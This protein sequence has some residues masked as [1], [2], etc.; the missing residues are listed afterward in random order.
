MHPKS[1]RVNPAR[2][3]PELCEGKV[4]TE[5]FGLVEADD[6]EV[7]GNYSANNQETKQR[8]LFPLLRCSCFYPVVISPPGTTRRA[9]AKKNISSR[10]QIGMQF[11]GGCP[12]Q[13]SVA[14]KFHISVSLDGD[15]EDIPAV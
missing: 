9:A 12:Y 13:I 3:A 10:H 7:G 2:G 11:L 6:C 15:F 1:A 14:I 4:S 8:P 5:T